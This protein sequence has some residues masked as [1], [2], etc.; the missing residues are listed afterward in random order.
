MVVDFLDQEIKVGDFCIFVGA[1][2]GGYCWVYVKNILEPK[3]TSWG[4]IHPNISVISGYKQE[5]KDGRIEFIINKRTGT[6]YPER[7][8]V[9]NEKIPSDLKEAFLNSIYYE[10]K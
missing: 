3:K 4:G 5:W 9:L 1:E 7:L 8:I 2:S 6:T 10:S